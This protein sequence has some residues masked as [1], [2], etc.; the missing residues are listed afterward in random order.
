MRKEKPP[1]S[2]P[3]LKIG[4]I[5]RI[6]NILMSSPSPMLLNYLWFWSLP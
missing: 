6:G 5:L 4:S 3:E 1:I 2:F